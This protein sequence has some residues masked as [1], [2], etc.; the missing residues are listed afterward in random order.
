[1]EEKQ[2]NIIVKTG[3]SGEPVMLNANYFQLLRKPTWTI[4]QYHV[5]FKPEIELSSL[6][7]YLI[8]TQ[9][10]FLGGYLFDGTMLF[11][12]RHL[13]NTP[14]VERTA[15]GRN[16]DEFRLLFKYTRKVS[17]ADAQSVQ[18]LNIILRRA[19]S[20]LKLQLVGRNFFD[21]DAKTTINEFKI[22]LWPGYVTSIRQHEPEILVCIEFLHKVMR[23]ETVY[24]I[25]VRMRREEQDFKSAIEREVLGTTVLTD[26]NN[27]TY[28]VDDIDYNKKPADTF[29]T[30]AGKLSFVE[31]YQQVRNYG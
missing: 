10:D 1:M 26:Y 8:A 29:D 28:Y 30:K 24:D 21:A 6:R 4:Y 2:S 5:E 7:R 23:M 11:L 18:I 15:V 13:E 27:K 3:H 22:E 16:N 20:G 17:P 12:T 25:M 14:V 19:M 9:K 31:Y